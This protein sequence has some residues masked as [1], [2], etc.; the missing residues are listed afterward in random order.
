M[1]KLYITALLSV[2][3]FN[4]IAQSNEPCLTQPLSF[5]QQLDYNLK[6]QAFHS[7]RATSNEDDTTIKYLPIQLHIVT[8][9]DQTGA[10][11]WEDIN[12]FIYVI[13][14]HLKPLYYQFFITDFKFINNSE[15]YDFEDR[16]END[17]AQGSDN[18][19]AINVYFV[20]SINGSLNYSSNEACAGTSGYSYHPFDDI[21]S[22]RVLIKNCF[23]NASEF[24]PV[25]HFGHFFG[26]VH[27]FNSAGS[28]RIFDPFSPEAENVVRAGEQ[29][30]CDTAAD[31]LCDTPADP[32]ADFNYLNWDTET[33]EY[34]GN[35]RDRF[36]QLYNPDTRNIMS[37]YSGCQEHF[38][39][40]Q[41]EKMRE[42]IAVRKQHSSY[43]FSA[44]SND[45]AMP[46]ELSASNNYNANTLLWKDNAD[47]ETGYIIER[48][49]VGSDDFTAVG[50]TSQNGNKFIDNDLTNGEQYHYRLRPSNSI[51]SSNSVVAEVNTILNIKEAS[52]I[53]SLSPVPTEGLVNIIGN[54]TN[55][56]INITVADIN[57]KIISSTSKNS[58]KANIDLTNHPN[59]IYIVTIKNLSTGKIEEHKV[60]KN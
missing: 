42:A 55:E 53:Y 24:A 28:G 7:K 13:N 30:N 50:S 38:S 9:D 5:Q 14:K 49:L 54:N 25:H 58:Q 32:G 16:E 46:S 47:N 59:G 56:E 43:D 57:G 1:N 10:I 52:N 40:G 3:G 60:L 6:A 48:A 19:Q 27:T 41:F 29:S 4:S 39:E 44:P 20:N 34:T 15:Y 33:C 37:Y 12:K 21:R 35:D 45:V 26:L 23:I 22:T 17:L 11:N 18:N 2:L 36:G 31:G 8:A 51:H